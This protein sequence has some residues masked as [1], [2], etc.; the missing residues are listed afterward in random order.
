MIPVVV[1]VVVVVVVPVVVVVVVVAVV[2]A[3]LA[4]S[5]MRLLV[6]PKTPPV[7]QCWPRLR[8]YVSNCRVT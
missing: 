2:V 7:T 8:T 6:Y 5:Y 3:A 4:G 1:A